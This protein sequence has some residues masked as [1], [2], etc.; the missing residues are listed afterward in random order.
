MKKLLVTLISL[1]LFFGYAKAVDLD[2]LRQVRVATYSLLGM[3]TTGTNHL[4]TNRVDEYVKYAVRFANENLLAY[5]KNE[6]IVTVDGTR[7]YA[8]DSVVSIIGA[9]YVSNDSIKSLQFI[10]LE[11]LYDSSLIEINDDGTGP[12]ERY[13]R[14]GDSVGFIPTPRDVD[15][16]LIFYCHVIPDDTLGLIPLSYRQGIVYLTASL[17]AMDIGRDGGLYMTMYQDFINR[18]RGVP[19]SPE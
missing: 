1:V 3:D 11:R 10:D 13:Y 16:M 14:W 5:K 18:K 7:L 9:W 12:P 2:T 15:S 17:A 8:L 4:P 6:I 19:I